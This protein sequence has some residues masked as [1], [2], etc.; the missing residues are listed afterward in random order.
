MPGPDPRSTWSPLRHTIFRWLW[1]ASVAS[2]VGTWFQNVGA[3]WLMT[4]IS[5]SPIL[6]SLVQADQQVFPGM[7]G[8]P[9]PWGTKRSTPLSHSFCQH[10]VLAAR[11]LVIDDARVHPLVRDNLAVRRLRRFYRQRRDEKP[12]R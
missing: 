9:E 8:L 3:S 11:P 2:N 7:T 10:V 1:I 6:V 12:W 5:P 4:T